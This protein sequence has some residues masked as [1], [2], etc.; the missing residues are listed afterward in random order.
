MRISL[1]AAAP[2]AV[3][4]IPEPV[5]EAIDLSAQGSDLRAE[6]SDLRAESRDLHAQRRDDGVGAHL[7]FDQRV[8]RLAAFLAKLAVFLFH[9]HQHLHAGLNDL[10][11][12]V[13]PLFHAI[14]ASLQVHWPQS[15]ALAR[16]PAVLA[17]AAANKQCRAEAYYHYD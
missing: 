7:R 9:L 16:A 1:A 4:A 12:C 11:G 2:G 15:S 17:P 6:G 5:D 3:A 8:N 10:E 14:H 13:E